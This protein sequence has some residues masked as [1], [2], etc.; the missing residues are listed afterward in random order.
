MWIELRMVRQFK[1]G[2][3]GRTRVYNSQRAVIEISEKR[4][5]NLWTFGVTLFHELLHIWTNIMKT[6]GAHIDM[7]KEHK[8]IYAMHQPLAK[9]I[10]KMKRR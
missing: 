2:S 3:L 10:P 9:H 4:N 6:N 8:F 1:D 7:R 5:T